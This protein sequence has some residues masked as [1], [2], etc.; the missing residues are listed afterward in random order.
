MTS[1]RDDYLKALKSDAESY[2][3][4][5]E[6]ALNIILDQDLE[7]MTRTIN[8]IYDSGVEWFEKTG[9]SDAELQAYKDKLA[10]LRD[11]CLADIEQTCSD[12]RP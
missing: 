5:M 7:L 8:E 11:E 2:P 9:G 10:K 6:E 3:E 1:A 12:L 4:G